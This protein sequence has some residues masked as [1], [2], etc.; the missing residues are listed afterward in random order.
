MNSR[1]GLNTNL[2]VVYVKCRS[3]V[4]GIESYSTPLT[5]G[6]GPIVSREEEFPV[7]PHLEMTSIDDDCHVEPVVRTY[8]PMVRLST[9]YI[10]IVRVGSSKEE[11]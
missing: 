8:G 11:T 5:S 2:E 1:L 9:E 10:S 6:Y 7:S 4:C 3:V